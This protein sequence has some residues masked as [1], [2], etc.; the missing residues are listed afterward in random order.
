MYKIN[1]GVDRPPEV[2]GIRGMNFLMIMAGATVGMLVLTALLIAVLGL[3]PMY[4]FGL[5]IVTVFVLY[6]NLI[7]YS[8]KY[9]ERGFSKFQARK[10]FPSVV[11]VR[12]SSVYRK[13][14]GEKSSKKKS[15]DE[16]KK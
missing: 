1:K 14:S 4:S 13:I 9:G 5:F 7:K 2:L 15:Y 3:N 10:R 8:K 12:S 11:L 6:N 16:R